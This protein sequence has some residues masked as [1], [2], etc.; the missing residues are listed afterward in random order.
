[1][2]TSQV[3]RALKQTIWPFLSP[4]GTLRVQDPTVKL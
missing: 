3:R 4:I 2:F 1:M